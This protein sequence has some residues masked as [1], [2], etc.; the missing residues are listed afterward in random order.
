M[1]VCCGIKCT[2]LPVRPRFETLESWIRLC[3]Y[4]VAKGKNCVLESP[5]PR[6]TITD[7]GLRSG[8]SGKVYDSA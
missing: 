2:L 7:S 6:T 3:I 5:P 1:F 4:Q 8:E